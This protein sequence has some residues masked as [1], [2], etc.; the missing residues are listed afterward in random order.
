MSFRVFLLSLFVSRLGDQILLF[1]VPLVVFQLT[2]SVAWSGLAFAAE[3]LPRYVSFPICG[4]LCDRRSPLALLQVSQVLRAVACL[5]GVAGGA[6]M[7]A[8]V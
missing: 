1:V 5:L 8:D 6:W 4:A 2:G 7:G 3:N